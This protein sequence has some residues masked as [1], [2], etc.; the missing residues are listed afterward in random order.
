[1]NSMNE[2]WVDANPHPYKTVVGYSFL[3]SMTI[4][5]MTKDLENVHRNQTK[6]CFFI[7]ILDRTTM[8]EYTSDEFAKLL[9][10]MK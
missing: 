4:D 7:L 6:N 8:L 10:T 5:L 1:M 2:K 3:C 9:K